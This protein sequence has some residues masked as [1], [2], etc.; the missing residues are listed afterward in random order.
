MA[1]AASGAVNIP[2]LLLNDAMPVGRFEGIPNDPDEDG[3]F[4]SSIELVTSC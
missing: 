2:P 3:G 1:I 4:I